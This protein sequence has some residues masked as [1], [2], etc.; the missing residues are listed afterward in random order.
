MIK[1]IIFVGSNWQSKR[2]KAVAKLSV[3]VAEFPNCIKCGTKNIGDIF[4]I[5]EEIRS[6]LLVKKISTNIF[7][8]CSL[9]CLFDR[10]LNKK[11]YYSV[12]VKLASGEVLSTGFQ[13]LN[14][15]A[16]NEFA[17]EISQQK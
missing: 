6:G 2:E 16:I 9:K 10:G 3:I 11:A 13:G 1:D 4:W 8:V 5:I 15:T 12:V 14:A 17:G 7:S